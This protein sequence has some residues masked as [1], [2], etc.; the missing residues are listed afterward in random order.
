MLKCKSLLPVTFHQEF[1][2]RSYW[3]AS[4]LLRSFLPTGKLLSH[5]EA[6]FLLYW[7]TGKLPYHWE[8]SFLLGSFLPT[9][10]LPSHLEASLLLGSFLPLGSF[11]LLGRLLTTA[12]GTFLQIYVSAL[13]LVKIFEKVGIFENFPVNQKNFP[14]H[15]VPCVPTFER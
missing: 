1:S 6:S 11:P 15:D 10:K 14:V 3:E 8:A 13:P 4:F 9:G 2:F 5:R 7:I 12:L